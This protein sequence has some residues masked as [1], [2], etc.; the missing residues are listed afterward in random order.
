MK[1]LL[2]LAI[3]TIP[4]AYLLVR[5]KPPVTIPLI[6]RTR[7]E[8]A[9]EVQVAEAK[10]EPPPKPVVVK[11]PTTKWKTLKVTATG[12]CPCKLCCHPFADGKTSTG[13]NAWRPGVAVDPKIIPLG[14]KVKIPG[15]V[16]GTV[17]ADDI[18]GAIKGRKIDVRF[19]Y[20]WQ[21]RNWGRQ[22]LT[23]KYLPRSKN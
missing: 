17:I 15:Y 14:S 1:K 10:S 23:I 18:G 2:A 16:Y 22:V 7:P 5:P 19:K 20:H 4:L 6:V 9:P 13:T 8:P 11:K 3:L 21:A 12:Y